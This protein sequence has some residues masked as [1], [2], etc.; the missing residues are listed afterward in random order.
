MLGYG[1]KDPD[2]I[3]EV[4]GWRPK[5]TVLTCDT[6]FKRGKKSA[7]EYR[8][9]IRCGLPV[10]VFASSWMDVKTPEK[11]WRLLKLWPQIRALLSRASG[12]PWISVNVLTNKAAL[13]EED[14]ADVP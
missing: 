4:A 9:V 2:W 8:Q 1:V 10:V 3:P 6:S 5:P 13:V 12:T 11:A 14:A 7:L